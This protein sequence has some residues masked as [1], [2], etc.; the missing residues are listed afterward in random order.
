MAG[1][2][3]SFTQKAHVADVTSRDDNHKPTLGDPTEI[4]VRYEE[5]VRKERAD[6]RVQ[7]LGDMFI[8]TDSVSED[9][10]FWPPDADETDDTQA[11]PIA[12]ISK[13]DSLASTKT[14]IEG[15]LE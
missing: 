14:I 15:T 1:I 5:N 2:D 9:Q 12:K 13:A 4:N 10:Y 7:V 6:G 3:S 11:R 8:T